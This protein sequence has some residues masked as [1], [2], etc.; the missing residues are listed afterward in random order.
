MSAEQT[1]KQKTM[2][3]GNALAA[4]LSYEAISTRKMLER[5]PAEIFQWQP[6]AKS[7]ELGNLAQHI[8]RLPSFVKPVLTADEFDLATA[9]RP[10]SPTSGEELVETFDKFLAEATEYLNNAA[11]EDL[12]VA[13]KLRHGDK[14]IFEMPR[15]GVVR[16]LVLSHLIHHRGQLSVYLRLNDVPVPSIYGPSADEQ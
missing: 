11:D 13:W 9:E 1:Q 6:H 2:T 16:S 15:A 4:E 12:T 7:M 10:A 5:V 3:V 8:S 14:T